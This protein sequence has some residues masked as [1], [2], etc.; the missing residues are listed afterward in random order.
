MCLFCMHSDTLC[1]Q[2]GLSYSFHITLRLNIVF[3]S[4]F[5][6]FNLSAPSS[7][8]SFMEKIIESMK[9]NASPEKQRNNSLPTV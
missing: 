5:F 3:I 8:A 1:S 4:L 2:G 6:F 9:R 7:S